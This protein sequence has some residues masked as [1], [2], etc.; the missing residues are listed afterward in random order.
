VLISPNIKIMQQHGEFV[1]KD[2]VFYSATLHPAAVLR[3]MNNKEIVLSDFK[4]I[5]EFIDT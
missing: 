2:G 1:L 5:F 3:N 4:K